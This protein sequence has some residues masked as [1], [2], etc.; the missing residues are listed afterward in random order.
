VAEIAPYPPEERHYRRCE[1]LECSTI[2]EAEG[3]RLLKLNDRAGAEV[4]HRI[5]GLIRIRR[6]EHL[7]PF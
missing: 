6:D 1:N 3:D 4:A 2:A 7:E 5:A